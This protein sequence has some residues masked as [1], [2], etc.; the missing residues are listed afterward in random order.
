MSR[1]LDALQRGEGY[2]GDIRKNYVFG[3]DMQL[4]LRR[5]VTYPFDLIARGLQDR[6]PAL[7]DARVSSVA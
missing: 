2:L 1:E 7:R 6:N 3:L 4:N 5:T